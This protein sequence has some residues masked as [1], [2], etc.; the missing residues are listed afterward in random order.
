M[1][2]G[3]LGFEVGEDIE[4]GR[5]GCAVIHFLFVASVP[6]EGFALDDLEAGEIDISFFPDGA[7]VR[8]K[9]LADDTDEANGSMETS[10]ESCERSG[11]AKE[12]G[13][14][15]FGGLHSV[16]ADRSDDENAHVRRDSLKG[17]SVPSRERISRAAFAGSG[18]RRR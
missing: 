4:I 7:V 10:G 11:T 18:A 12:V 5:E 3:E 16:D 13:A 2:G 1:R 14:I 9:I 17:E 8:W 15:F 6:A